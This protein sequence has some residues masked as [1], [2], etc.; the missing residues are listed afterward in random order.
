MLVCDF[1]H[2]EDR[3]SGDES[4]EEIVKFIMENYSEVININQTNKK[5]ETALNLVDAYDSQVIVEFLMKNYGYLI[6]IDKENIDEDSIIPTAL[7]EHIKSEE[8]KKK[9]FESIEKIF[10]KIGDVVHC[11]KKDNSVKRDIKDKSQ[12]LLNVDTG[13]GRY[14][15]TDDEGVDVFRYHNRAD[16]ILYS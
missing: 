5:G 3:D 2:K 14:M 13:Y 16:T 6:N 9:E 11:Y 1:K 12:L 10:V 7:T 15:K 8:Y 4:Y